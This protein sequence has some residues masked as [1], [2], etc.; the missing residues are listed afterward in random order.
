MTL[1][2]T[3][4]SI[5]IKN[6]R[7][8]QTRRPQRGIERSYHA[9]AERHPAHHQNVTQQQIHWQKRHRIHVCVEKVF[10]LSLVIGVDAQD[11]RG[12]LRFEVVSSSVCLTILIDT[13]PMVFRNLFAKI[14]SKKY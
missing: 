6:H 9:H 11:V 5:L 8:R 14:V 10:E 7:R 3:L 2:L 13:S 4:I 12:G 1:F